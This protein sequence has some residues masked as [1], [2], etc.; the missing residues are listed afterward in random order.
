MNKIKSHR[1]NFHIVLHMFFSVISSFLIMKSSSDVC[2]HV[3]PL[4][5]KWDSAIKVS[6]DSQIRQIGNKQKKNLS[7]LHE[8]HWRL[9][10]RIGRQTRA[11]VCLKRER[12]KVVLMVLNFALLWSSEKP[13]LERI[14]EVVW[15]RSGLV[16]AFKGALPFSGSTAFK[17]CPDGN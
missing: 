15:V 3:K 10:K 16:K 8:T 12:G 11:G 13:Y 6:L 2:T 14:P 17:V 5:H 9:Q 4:L 7:D 1:Y